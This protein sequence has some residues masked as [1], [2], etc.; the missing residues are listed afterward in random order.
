MAMVMTILSGHVAADKWS[1]MVGMYQE[2]GNHKP[3]Q[4]VQGFLVQS[5]ED[6]SHWQTVCIWRSPEALEEYHA[7]GQPGGAQMFRA[8][9]AEAS[10]EK[11]EV[12]HEMR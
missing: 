9:G 8:M 1:E 12:A 3:Q 11:F 5:S 6:P 4:L 2:G 10:E 7:S